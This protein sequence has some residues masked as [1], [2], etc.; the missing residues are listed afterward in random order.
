MPGEP[1]TRRVTQAQ[2]RSYLAEADEFPVAGDAI[3]GTRTGQRSAGTDRAQAAALLEHAGREGKDAAR[4]L[5]R[6]V[7]L[8]N[9]AEYEPNDIPK[10]TATRAVDQGAPVTGRPTRHASD[11]QPASISSPP[12]GV[13]G[14]MIGRATSR[15]RQ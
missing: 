1:R 13:I 6:L 5:S 12:I 11:A 2:A 3:C 15:A 9:R 8:K 4:L 10:A 14:P 7:P